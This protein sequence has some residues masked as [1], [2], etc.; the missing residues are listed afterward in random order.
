MLSDYAEPLSTGSDESKPHGGSTGMLPPPRPNQIDWKIAIQIASLVAFI[1]A[2]LGIAGQRLPNLSI[3]SF[4]W[5]VSGSLTTLALYQRRRP[6]ASMN[7]RIG[8]KI[9]ILVG[10]M[11]AF[12]LGA[13][14]SVGFFVARFGMHALSYFD[15]EIARLMKQQVEQVSAKNPISPDQLAFIYSDQFRTGYLLFGFGI[16][17]FLIFLMSIFGG[18]I[19]GLLRTRR[20]TAA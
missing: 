3:F 1:A 16:V 20:S 5:V 11:L 15:S 17:L 13:A 9:G 8:I 14:M 7:L 10:V 12:G 6:L 4:V 18:A 19:G 2:I